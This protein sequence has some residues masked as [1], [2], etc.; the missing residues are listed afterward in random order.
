MITFIYFLYFCSSTVYLEERFAPGWENRWHKPKHVRKGVQLGRVRL[1]AGDFYG[2]ER[3]QRGMQTMD[4]QR[5]YLLY[6]N[7]THR[8]D[9]RDRDLIIQY[10]VRLHYY[11]DCGGQY[12]KLL[13]GDA[14]VGRFSNETDYLLMFGPDI[15][16]ATFRRTH[17]II[18]YKGEHYQ[19]LHPLNCF[20]DHLTHSYTLIIRKNNTIEVQIDGE[21]VDEGAL[22]SHFPI[23]PV[24]QIPDPDDKKPEDWDDDEWIVDPKDKKPKNWVDEEFI[25][26]PDAFKPPSWDDSIV[27][28]PQM[29]RNP[30]YIG[31]W[32]PR[33]IKNPNYKGP[34]KPKM[35]DQK[36]EVDPTFGHFSDIAYLGLE[37]FQNVPDSIFNN[38]LI[39]D[40]EEYAR[41]M[42]EDVYLS[43]REEEVRNFDEQSARLKKQKDI[44]SLRRDKD[45]HH[46]NND[47]DDFTDSSDD[48]NNYFDIKRKQA[49]KKKKPANI[50]QFDSL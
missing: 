50:D 22:D 48:D 8:M 28:A 13:G 47:M 39:T 11:L 35:I 41:K 34:W 40:D 14:D 3:K 6:S 5:N 21:V 10:T 4:A 33:I 18:S 44:E 37:F 38:F 30:D 31:E 23:P 1:S 9:T 26:D 42:L 20:K 43:I 2:D 36:A 27:W 17:F 45:D 46:R 7:L 25:P 29:I 16:G 24:D 15:C 32:T 12:I 19:T 49:K